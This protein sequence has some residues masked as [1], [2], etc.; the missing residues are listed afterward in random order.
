MLPDDFEIIPLRM[1]PV[2]SL[3]I[4]IQIE[5]CFIILKK[6]NGVEG[7]FEQDK[8]RI[9]QDYLTKLLYRYDQDV[10]CVSYMFS[11]I[12][13]RI[14]SYFGQDLK[15][16]II[17]PIFC[18]QNAILSQDLRMIADVFYNDEL[19]S[20]FRIQRAHRVGEDI[21]AMILILFSCGELPLNESIRKNKIFKEFFNYLPIWRF[22]IMINEN[23][24]LEE[25]KFYEVTENNLLILNSLTD[26]I[27]SFKTKFNNYLS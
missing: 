15:D 14:L 23:L 6:I 2:I 12:K 16:E 20:K 8:I 27:E 13:P 21:L 3:N 5:K 25:E 24:K 4:L 11:R 1:M 10:E 17:F 22:K 26:V 19:F 18:I 7:S 9:C